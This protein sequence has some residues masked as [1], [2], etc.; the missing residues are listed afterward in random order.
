[1]VQ[2]LGEQGREF[3][4]DPAV[5]TCLKQLPAAVSAGGDP[6]ACAREVR[7]AAGEA[8]AAAQVSSQIGE[9]ALDALTQTALAAPGDTDQAVAEFARSFVAR[10]V[11]YLGSR[12]LSA[13]LGQEGS[14]SVAAAV[15]LL[16][17]MRNE[18]REAS[19]AG[20]GS[21]E[22]CVSETLTALAGGG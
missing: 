16:A 13:H 2:A 4:D 20:A 5:Q 7:R 3:Q 18:A 22:E 10:A 12:D 6:M 14:P 8:L 1:M 17:N 15:D 21:F 19:P 9:V 11:E